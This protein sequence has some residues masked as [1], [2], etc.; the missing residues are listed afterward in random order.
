MALAF[1][2]GAVVFT[3]NTTLGV[4]D[5]TYDGQPIIVSNCTLTVNGPHTFASLLLTSNA[6]L[7]HATAPNGETN[8]RVLLSITGDATVDAS[9]SIDASA[10]GYS[11]ASGPGAGWR[12]VNSGCGAGHGGMGGGGAVFNG[13]EGGGVAY[14]SML[15]P[16]EFGSGGGNG[17]S[18]HGGYGGGV[19][20]LSI[21]GTLQVDGTV[22]ANGGG[23]SA[24]Y[25]GGGAGGN[26]WIVANTLTG[27]GTISANGGSVP[28]NGGGGGGGGGRVAVYFNNDSFAGTLQALGGSGYQRGSA[29]TLFRQTNGAAHGQVCI[30]NGGNASRPTTLTNGFWPAGVSFDLLCTGASVVEAQGPMTLASLRVNGGAV[31]NHPRQIPL[32]LTVT[33]DVVIET[34]GQINVTGLGYA[35][36]SGPGAGGTWGHYGSGG[37]YGGRGAYGQNGVPGGG[38][39][40]LIPIPTDFGSGGGEG[41][42]GHGGYGGGAIQLSVGGTLQVDGTLAAGGGAMIYSGSSHYAGGGSGGSVWI[43]A[44]TFAGSGTVSA[45]GGNGGAAGGGGGGGRIA[46]YLDNDN[47]A[48]AIQTL[49]GSGYQRGGAGTVFRQMNGSTR[50]QVRIDNGGNVSTAT[51]LTNAFWPTGSSFDLLCAGASVLHVQGPMTLASLR[52]NGGAVLSH[53]AQQSN[54]DL[55][56]TGDLIIET[57]GQINVTGLGYASASGPGAGGRWGDQGSGGGH[58]GQ[59]GYTLNGRY[60]GSAYDSIRSPLTL[61][62][63]GGDGYQGH[64]GYGGGAIQLS[65]G[66]TLQVDGTLA[67]DGGAMSWAGSDYYAGG[68]SGGSVWVTAG[69]FAGNGSVSANGGAGGRGSGGGGGGGRIAVFYGTNLFVGTITAA[70]GSGYRRGGAGTIFTQASSSPRGHVLVDNA[71]AGGGV[72]VLRPEFW[73]SGEVFDLTATGA[74]LVYPEHVSMPGHLRVNGGAV[75]SH[76]SQQRTFNLSIAGDLAIETN[77][78]INVVGI[79]YPV[80]TGPGAGWQ[81]YNGNGGGGGHGGAGGGAQVPNNFQGSGGTYDSESLPIEFGSGSGNSQGGGAGGGAIRLSVAGTLQLDGGIVAGGGGASDTHAGGGSGGSLLLQV[82]TLLGGGT[83]SANGGASGT[84]G[85]GG[86]GGGGRI[87]LYFD[88]LTG[89]DTNQITA[90]GGSGAQWGYNG[91]VFLATVPQVPVIAVQPASNSIALA[92]VTL[93]S[94]ALGSPTLRYQWFH[95]GQALAGATGMALTIPFATL[96]SAQAGNYFVVVTNA[97]GAATSQVAS[98]TVPADLAILVVAGPT[99]AVPGAPVNVVWTVTNLG[100]GN[101]S[102]PW[103]ARLALANDAAGN[104]A[105]TLADVTLG[106][107][108]AAGTSVVLTNTVIFPPSFTGQKWFVVTADPDNALAEVNEANNACVAASTVTLP[109]PDLVV[110]EVTPPPAALFG[111]TIA[112]SWAVTNAGTATASSTWS[113]KLYLSAASDSLSGATLL[114][115]AAANASPLAV[116]GVYTRTQTVTLPL[117]AQSAAGSYFIVAVADAAGTLQEG[118]EANNLRSAPLALTLPPM[119]DLAVENVIAPATAQANQ[120]FTLIWSVTNRGTATATAPWSES[121]IVSNASAGAQSLLL[122]DTTNT[123]AIGAALTRTQTVVLPITGPAGELQFFVQTDS[124]DERVELNEANNLAAAT[125]TTSVPLLLTL[126]VPATQIAENAA[127]PTLQCTLVRNGDRSAALTVTLTNSDVTEVTA[128]AEVTIPAGL[129]ST[130]LNLQVLADGVVDGPQTVTIGAGAAGYPAAQAQLV[131]V[132][133][134]LPFLAVSFATNRVSEGAALSGLVARGYVTT[135]ALVVTL[136]SSAPGQLGVPASVVIPAGSNSATFT[137]TAADDTLIEPA[138]RY[139]V[140]ASAAGFV[141]MEAELEILDDDVP[142]VLLNLA[143]ATV[144]EAAGPQA[145]LGSV[146]RNPV[147]TRAVTI[148]LTSSDTTEALVPPTVTI[149]ANEPTAT[150]NVVAVDD[151]AVDGAQTVQIGGFVLASQTSAQ[152]AAVPAAALTVT[153]NDGPA[154]TLSVSPKLLAEGVLPAGMGTVSRNTPATNALVVTV[155]SSDLT[156]VSNPNPVAIPVGQASATFQIGT[157]GDGVNDGSHAVTL[158][159]TAAGFA[160]ASELVTVTDADLPDLHVASITVPPLAETESYINVSYRVA[161]QGFSAT[162][163]NFVTRVFLSADPL[164]GDDTLV[165]QYQ[166]NG[167]LPVGLSFEQTLSVRLPQ[168]A[169][170]RWIIVQ[171]D[172]G[173][174]VDEVLEDNNTGIS[175]APISVSAAYSAWAQTALN[176]ALAGTPVPLAGRATNSAGAGVAYKLVNLH[177]VVRGTERVISALTDNSGNFSA[178]FQPL[179]NEGGTY[180]VFATH[181]G[182]T[183]APVQDSFSLLGL[184]PDATTVNI[185]VVEGSSASGAVA[186]QN[187]GDVPLTGLTATV[188]NAPPQLGVSVGFVSNSVPGSASANLVYSFTAPTDEGSGVVSVHLTS[189]EG[190]AADVYFVV[191]VESLRPRL[192]AT[193]GQLTAGMARGRQAT[194]EFVV[195]NLGGV[196]TGPITVSLPVAPWLQLALPNPLPSLEPGASNRVTLLLTPANDL[197]LTAFTGNLAVNCASAGLSVPFNFRCLS[198]AKGDLR[199]EA[200][201][202]FTYF[203]AGSPKLTNASVVVRDAVSRVVMTNGLTDAQGQFFAAGLAEGYYSLEVNAWKHDGYVATHLLLAGQ[204]NEVQTFLP[205][206]TVQYVWKVVPTEVED[207]TKI[208]IETVFEAFVPMPVVTITPALIDLSEIQGD[209]AQVDLLI[210]NHGLIAAQ[211][212]HFNLPLHTDWEFTPLV[213]DVGTIPA[214]SSLSIPLTIRRL[215]TGGKGAKDS[216]S[217]DC[218]TAGDGCYFFDCGKYS[219]NICLPVLFSNTRSNC[220]RASLPGFPGIYIPGGS[221]PVTGGL[222]GPSGSDQVNVSSLPA[223]V[224]ATVV[225]CEECLEKFAAAALGCAADLSGYDSLVLGVNAA[226]CITHDDPKACQQALAGLISAPLSETPIGK[227]VSLINCLVSLITACEA[228][229]NAGPADPWPPISTVSSRTKS[230]NGYFVNKLPSGAADHFPA[231]TTVA[232]RGDRLLAEFNLMRLYMGDDAWFHEG[233]STNYG[234]WL[235]AFSAR[236]DATSAEGMRVSSAERAELLSAVWPDAMVETNLTKFL[237]RWN[238]TQDYYD[239]GIQKL[240]DVPSGQSKDFIPLDVFSNL[241]MMAQQ[242]ALANEADG[243]TN[244]FD[245]IADAYGNLRAEIMAYTNSGGGVCAQ[246]R[247]ALDQDAVISR[248]AFKASLEIINN[249]D[250]LLQAVSV[251]VVI[252]NAAGE[253]ATSLFGI[254]PPTLENLTAVDGSGVIDGHTTGRATWTLLPSSDAAPAMPTVYSVSGTLRYTQDGLDVTVPLAPAAITVHPN[255]RVFVKYF[256]QRDVFSDDPFTDT[257]EP[258]VPFNLAVMVRNLGLGLAKNVRIT[259]AQPKIVENEKGLLVDFQIIGTEVAGQNLTP[260]LTASFGEIGAGE[261]AIGRWL[262]TSTVQGLFEEYKASFE[263]VDG[264]GNR[265]LS[266]IEEVTIHEMNHLVWA[267]G[268]FEDGRPDFLVNG[269]PDARDLPDTLYL[270]DGRTNPVSVVETA[271]VDAA[272]SAQHLV[273]QLTAPM[274]AGWTYLRVADPGN[275]AFILTNVVCTSNGARIPLG[276]NAW[277]TDRTFLGLGRR[278]VNENILHLLDYNSAGAYTLYYT[279]V[280]Q[281]DTTAPTSAVAVL[282]AQ[283]PPMFQVAWS[284][285]DT[286]GSG[287]AF[288]DVFV[289][290]NDGMFTPWLQHTPLTAAMFSAE[291]GSRY[292]FYSVATDQQGNRE[293]APTTPDAATSATLTNQPPVL[294]PLVAQTVDEGDTLQLTLSATDDEGSAIRYT[295]GA[296]APAGA[297]LNPTSGQFTWATTEANGPS[298]NTLTV[299]ATDNGIPP[300][301]ASQPL[302]II[303][304]E[305]NT[306]PVLAGY[307]NRTVNEGSLLTVSSSAEDFDVPAN[308]LRYRLGSD[309]PTGVSLDATNGV[310]RWRPSDLQGPSTNAIAIVVYDSGSPSLSATQQLTVIVRDTRADFTLH[311]GSTNLLAGANNFVPLRLDTGA[312]LTN[313]T[314]VLETDL[315]RLTNLALQSLA[316]EVASSG[317]QQV[318]SNRFQLQ[319]TSR[320]D[321]SLQG[322]L[323]LA[324]LA[325]GA[326][327]AEH[328]AVVPLTAQSLAGYLRDGRTLDRGAAGAGRVFVIA[329]EPIVDLQRA[330]NNVAS[331]SLYGLPG[332]RYAFTSATNLAATATWTAVRDL[333]LSD[334]GNWS[335]DWTITA[336]QGFTRA[337]EVSGTSLAVRLEAGKVVVEWPAACAGCELQESP[338]LNAGAAWTRCE[339]QPQLSGGRYRAELP[340]TGLTGFY[341]LKLSQ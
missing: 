85:P 202:E 127:S 169:G 89:F 186:I 39:Y 315:G 199:I 105:V 257:V 212:F 40:G 84:G 83:I 24:G 276:T 113:D 259:S 262:M 219:R 230:E 86:G 318:G 150:F 231:I 29:G 326:V 144:G 5:A 258:S 208:T 194:V 232:Q 220:T 71:G 243:I 203:A 284:G 327:P 339:T 31:V 189:A 75:L 45:N 98:V 302:T 329:R 277:T 139:T 38:G 308:T 70:G 253:V 140:A 290:V 225:S 148:A 67:T 92:D 37:G 59:G 275:G 62:S 280:P 125:N 256:H 301:S 164:P 123:L 136:T 69:T 286:N 285:A 87:A 336:P 287:V 143:S 128:P 51:T 155:T 181:P 42:R 218:D 196:A 170:N 116:G 50:G 10:R 66:G 331:L 226:K 56:V 249:A 241:V 55:T 8:N 279:P 117:T 100:P 157:V 53:A 242:A 153:D 266:L 271:T 26:L 176:T 104:G 332:Q 325:F 239:V 236:T 19:I 17:D 217:S 20:R 303:V 130:V 298:T 222:A 152:V 296:G 165:A 307:T 149:P 167:S 141:G 14:D 238:R 95:D 22:A 174:A 235:A 32:N 261:T 338:S 207:V 312:D 183:S 28:A 72:T 118:N 228:G 197:A 250:T 245:G 178:T 21:G 134:D 9:S 126:Q 269:I 330:S 233:M 81:A 282:P 193:P 73:A 35:S 322:N 1:N 110:S 229:P 147:T 206:Q 94:M 101:I 283:S 129:P 288:Y 300:A 162:R 210:E 321:A 160:P 254:A 166:F 79:G 204:T 156:E 163:S 114:A 172:A 49:G 63:G 124:R 211:G 337:V 227:V 316:S 191:D 292:A 264:L 313:L 310:L 145:T 11:S 267:G 158:T 184:K 200:V 291:L 278:P 297:F 281:P 168:G 115:T 244:I 77:G 319:F 154:L 25:S 180:Q 57:N 107:P 135:N 137:A 15:L 192:V 52:V 58:G 68:G 177:I 161:N 36:A 334:A 102:A 299:I 27:H 173:T 268:A 274:L 198:E 12:V 97:N 64:G 90:S 215:S 214:R 205:R 108:V 91:T 293:A 294:A 240:S 224:S 340:V 23:P 41:D 103:N 44:G 146:T 270:S 328:S 175:L 272:P 120:A 46:I 263:H 304:R 182:V 43:T 13:Y 80:K 96:T 201:D 60:G 30:D 122:L 216:R 314:F 82:G 78:Q 179:T 132:D 187:L 33:G 309:V 65:V 121:L 306:A 273:V 223:E 61:G 289:S 209:E 6:V 265:K 190:T 323:T 142:Q 247:L 237:D 159:A 234:V 111:D 335:G 171:T 138:M 3:N 88:N 7:T 324:R 341:R 54:F 133:A 252:S 151:P 248:D 119:P 320:A 195:Q 255:P 131:V 47:F 76:A 333:V 109:S 188:S 93:A 99:E 185:R 317:I 106:T 16:V 48:G 311:V 251:Q 260:S 2:A 221:K 112:V 213:S 4:G 34:N 18:G 74:A 246:V 295:L 305:V